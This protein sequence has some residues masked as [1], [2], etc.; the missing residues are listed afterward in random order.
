MVFGAKL[1]NEAVCGLGGQSE[2]ASDHRSIFAASL[3][4][5]GVWNT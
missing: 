1:I 3:K 2:L 5:Y 4:S